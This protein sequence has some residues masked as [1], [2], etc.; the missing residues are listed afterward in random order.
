MLTA[1]CTAVVLELTAPWT[2]LTAVP[3]AEL[4]VLATLSAVLVTEDV[5][6]LSA[7][8]MDPK[9]SARTP[10]AHKVQSIRATACWVHIESAPPVLCSSRASLVQTLSATA[11]QDVTYCLSALCK[12]ILVPK[13]HSN[14]ASMLSMRI[15]LA[16]VTIQ[17]GT[18]GSAVEEKRKCLAI[19]TDKRPDGSIARCGWPKQASR[20]IS[21]VSAALN[22]PCLSTRH[23]QSTCRNTP[24][25]LWWLGSAVTRSFARFC[26][27]TFWSCTSSANL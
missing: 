13:A 24:G 7:L 15:Q 20:C 22:S 8:L 11:C 19:R 21:R 18:L 1:F 25:G 12:V 14:S 10:V 9:I 3:V 27:P 2:A 17:A 6:L 5:A 23:S 16:A 4:T 26:T